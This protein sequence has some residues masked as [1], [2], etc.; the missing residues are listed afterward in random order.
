MSLV[1]AQ[2]P[3][4]PVYIAV[5]ALLGFYYLSKA[6]VRVHHVSRKSPNKWFVL[7]AS[8]VLVV[9]AFSAVMYS[10]Y[11]VTNTMNEAIDDDF[12]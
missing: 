9:F 11:I 10:F 4:F 1:A 6:L 7:A 5:F 8:S 12:D 3:P 2:C